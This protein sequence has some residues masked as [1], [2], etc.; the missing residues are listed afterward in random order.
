MLYFFG[1]LAGVVTGLMVA[2]ALGAKLEKG[3]R[4]HIRRQI[5]Q[6]A[7]DHDWVNPEH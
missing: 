3:Y 6:E 2:G 4:A 1:Y 5:E 7:L